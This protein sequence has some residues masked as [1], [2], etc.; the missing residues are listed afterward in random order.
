M[1]YRLRTLLIM[2]GAVPPL[3]AVQWWFFTQQDFGWPML[4]W[5][6]T[7]CMDAIVIY[8]LMAAGATALSCLENKPKP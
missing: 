4:I 8:Y 3:L 6:A 7:A 5:T 1:R 2:M